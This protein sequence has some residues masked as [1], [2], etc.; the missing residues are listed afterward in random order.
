MNTAT[1]VKRPGGRSAQVQAVVRAA[2]E[3]LVAEHGRDKVTVP[4]LA[5]RSGISASSIYRRWGDVA[6]L[7]AETATHRLDP[8]RPMPDTGQLKS[9]LVAWA[10]ELITHLAKPANT[11]LL[12]AAAAL[13][14]NED[15]N[16]L[17]NRR[18]EAQGLIQRAVKRGEAVPSVPRV[19]DH[20]VAPIIYRVIFSTETV[21]LAMA[22]RL[23]DELFVLMAADA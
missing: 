14:G 23:I 18:S 21:E 19:I 12:K 17:R 3:E 1:Q 13:A 20:V 5:E 6:G 2:L 4:A 7:L 8:T 9:D 16:C 11:S 22:A 15:T 10:E